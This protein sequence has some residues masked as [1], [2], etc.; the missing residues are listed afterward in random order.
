MEKYRVAI[1]IPALNEAVTIAQIVK[2]VGT[3]GTPIV[4]DDG[5]KDATAIIAENCGAIVCIHDR[6][7]GYDEAIQTG[8]NLAI[9]QEFEFAVTFDA[10]NQFNATDIKKFIDKFYAGADMVIG[11]R[12]R[13]QRLS[14]SIFG[15]ISKYLW[16]IYD[17]LCGMKGYRLC[18][19]HNY[20]SFHTYNSAGTELCLRI[21][22]AN[23]KISQIEVLIN[24]RMD[25]PRFGNFLSA[26]IK[27]LTSLI[28][29]FLYT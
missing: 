6:N 1:I 19:L 25:K 23:Y 12:N 24:E 8:L 5:S 26:N 27:I 22:K 10:D 14:E 3:Y 16:G 17:P 9:K 18:L 29:T 28:K 11:I 4:V 13:N 21:A 15:L 2:A 20:K 7:K